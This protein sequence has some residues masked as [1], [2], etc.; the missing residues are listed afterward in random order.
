MVDVF[1]TRDHVHDAP[2]EDSPIPPV[3]Y[4]PPFD[5]QSV[6]GRIFVREIY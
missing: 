3:V 2:D 6:A 5:L 4:E 1:N